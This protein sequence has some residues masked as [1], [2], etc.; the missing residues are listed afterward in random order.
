[1]RLNGRGVPTLLTF[2]LNTRPSTTAGLPGI[3]LPVGLS[4]AGLP[5][6][7][8]F[9]GAHGMDRALLALGLAAEAVWGSLPKPVEIARTAPPTRWHLRKELQLNRRV[10]PW[11]VRT[12]SPLLCFASRSFCGALLLIGHVNAELGAVQGFAPMDI[13]ELRQAITPEISPD[14]RRLAYTMIVRDVQTDTRVRT[15]QLSKDLR[16]WTQLND[17]EGC[18]IAGWAPDSR[19]LALVCQR[20]QGSVIEVRDTDSDARIAVAQSPFPIAGVAWAHDA[21]RLAYE[22]FVAAPPMMVPGIPVPPPGAKWAVPFGPPEQRLRMSF[23]GVGDL[24]NGSF[25]TFVVASNAAGRAQQLTDG[26][27]WTGFGLGPDLAWSSD[28]AEIF[29]SALRTPDWD[30]HGGERDIYAVHARGGAV[31]RLTDLPGAE[32]NLA[33]SPDGKLLAFTAVQ[34][35]GLSYQNRQLYVMPLPGGKPE[36]LSGKL[37]RSIGQLAWRADGRALLVSYEDD[38]THSLATVML[39]GKVVPFAHELGGDSLELPFSYGSFSVSRSGAVAYVRSTSTVPSDVIVKAGNGDGH[40]VTDL[41][42]ALARRIGGFIP[43]RPLSVAARDGTPL[44]GWVIR[45]R[46]RRAGEHSPVILDIHGGPYAQ[47]ADRFSIKYQL[48]AAAGYSIVYSNPRGSTG[49]GEAFANTTHDNWPGPDYD[50]LIDVLD[51]AI[52]EESFDAENQFVAGT[53]SGAMMSLWCVGHTDRFR[54]AAVAKV[55]VDMN[56]WMLTS[57]V[58]PEY[59]RWFGNVLPWNDPE[60]YW[61]RS[62]LSLVSHIHTP[63]LLITGDQD[64]RTPQSGVREMYTAL[65]LSGVETALLRGVNVSHNSSAYRPSMFLQEVAYSRW[66]FD[67]HKRDAVIAR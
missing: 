66:W 30:L 5:V 62:A 20:S 16:T 35:R 61:R 9:D 46:A 11:L 39:N 52:K 21:S 36:L 65:K 56:S 18:S 32:T 38:G 22:G 25:Q 49:Y 34:E 45:S 6:G 41:N 50:D 29:F 37:D 3:S 42:S 67:K 60:K 57:D 28:D 19:R 53:S 7:L 44:Q 64:L 40:A 2:V 63:V 13:F 58:G 43:A 33:V 10:W 55:P 1:V 59:L 17:S 31:R 26:P 27:S 23:D 51:A 54:A 4:A 48:L 47:Y 14:G 12:V 24:P 15:I 8:E